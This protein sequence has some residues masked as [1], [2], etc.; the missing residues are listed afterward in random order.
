LALSGCQRGEIAQCLIRGET[1][2]AMEAA[3]RYL[4]VFGS[5]RFWIEV[6][7]HME[8]Y[9][10]RL[11]NDL[12]ALANELGIGYVATDNVHYATP[13]SRPLQDVLTSIRCWNSSLTTLRRLPTP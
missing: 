9:D 8:G 3:Q 4:E 13:E 12:I 6:Q 1:K 10:H 2:Q 11:S 5:G 7:R